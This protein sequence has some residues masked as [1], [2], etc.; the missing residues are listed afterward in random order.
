MSPQSNEH[1]KSCARIAAMLNRTLGAD[2]EVR[3]HSSL[4]AGED[5]VPEPDV[6]VV[7]ADP[8]DTPPTR[9]FLV[10]E[11]SVTSLRKDRGIKA[12]I[13][14]E[15]EFPEY[16]IVDLESRAV[17]VHTDPA[18]GVYRSV[19][20]IGDEGVLRPAAFPEVAIPVAE[21]VPPR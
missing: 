14:A 1:A 21:I 17:E 2:M 10:V 3:S 5:S 15:A 18:G 9:T 6:A 12:S 20:R 11:V 7:S 4:A 16:W 13:Y 8:W 19:V